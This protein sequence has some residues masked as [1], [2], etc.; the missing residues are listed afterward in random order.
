[1][2]QPAGNVSYSGVRRIKIFGCTVTSDELKGF[3]LTGY[4]PDPPKRTVSTWAHI[5]PP[6]KAMAP[7]GVARFTSIDVSQAT[8]E[9]LCDE[10][11]QHSEAPVDA[12]DT[13][14]LPWD[15]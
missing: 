5:E 15:D 4:W 10:R 14:K 9:F 2:N 1:M 7:R 13:Y 11:T 6:A 3:Y 8:E 12:G